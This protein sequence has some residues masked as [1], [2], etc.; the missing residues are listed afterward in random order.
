MVELNLQQLAAIIN[1]EDKFIKEFMDNKLY[2]KFNF[3]DIMGTS[4]KLLNEP[5]VQ[6]QEHIKRKVVRYWEKGLL[7]ESFK[8]A[9]SLDPREE[10]DGGW[11]WNG[12]LIVDDLNWDNPIF[13]GKPVVEVVG[14]FDC[15]QSDLTSLEGSPKIIARNFNCYRNKL[16]S[17]EGGPDYVGGD[18]D[19]HHNELTS[20]SG[21]P[22][23]V[24]GD[25]DVGPGI[26]KRNPDLPKNERPDTQIGG[27][28]I[29]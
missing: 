26:F 23:I 28:F 15:S 19:C 6:E 11:K 24:R 12:N 2:E 27:E 10:V 7:P 22:K 5:L 20:L 4:I 21:A 13:E 17:L 14:N 16:V 18:F 9:K 3:G 25:F 1:D 29:N 8:I